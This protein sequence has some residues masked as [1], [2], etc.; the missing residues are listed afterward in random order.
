MNATEPDTDLEVHAY[1][2]ELRSN[3]DEK[4]ANFI[5]SKIL[6]MIS[7]HK[8]LSVFGK[9]YDEQSLNFIIRYSYIQTPDK[10]DDVYLVYSDKVN[11]RYKNVNLVS[12]LQS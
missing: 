11:F 9:L 12:I 6:Y 2:R 10:V 4:H 3:K 8:A 7:F 5:T 1:L